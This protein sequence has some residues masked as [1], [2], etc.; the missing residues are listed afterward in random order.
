M[1]STSELNKTF[2]SW[3]HKSLGNVT[4]Q[5]LP[6]NFTHFTFPAGTRLTFGEI[7]ALAGDYF[8][9]AMAPISAGTSEAKRRQRFLDA[10]ATLAHCAPN[11]VYKLTKMIREEGNEPDV[12]TMMQGQPS[13]SG[14]DNDHADIYRFTKCNYFSLLVHNVDHFNIQAHVAFRTGYLM[15]LDV[16][17]RAGQLTNPAERA[18]QLEYAYS[19]LGFS[20][21]YL[22]DAFASGHMRTPRTAL[23]KQFGPYLGAILSLFQHDE[24]G[25]LGLEVC[26]MNRITH[27]TQTWTSFGDGHLFEK[28]SGENQEKAREA[29]QMAADELYNAFINPHAP[30]LF[31]NSDVMRM[32]PKV[33]DNNFPPMFK[34]DSRGRL[35]CRIPIGGKPVNA[36]AELTRLRVIELLAYHAELYIDHFIREKIVYF[37]D[38][39]TEELAQHTNCLSS[40][41]KFSL[42]Q[43]GNSQAA[44]PAKNNKSNTRQPCCNIL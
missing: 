11:D 24:D 5:G 35:M 19:L 43:C 4:L 1:L 27:A 8:G 2:D 14:I 40:L 29:V 39:L 31:K 13:L 17:R 37:K 30:I 44:A 20:C 21:H 34:V 41:S 33:T 12:S 36:Y 22:T 26:A 9:V 38:K 16:A 6:K 3:E 28:E 15:A 18:Q 32:I 25:D 7:I 42:F 10:Y 23:E